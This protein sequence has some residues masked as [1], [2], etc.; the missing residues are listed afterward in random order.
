MF[1]GVL[2]A[3]IAGYI[4]LVG[5]IYVGQRGLMY[6]PGG[7][8]GPPT[9][10]GVGEM[11]E[12]PLENDAGHTLI[13]WYAAPKPN[14]PV[15]IFFHG[16][17]GTIGDRAEKI[18]PYLNAGFGVVLA[19]YRG[20]GGNPGSPSEAGL[21]NDAATILGHL[22]TNGIPP[23]R[24]VVYGESLGTGVATEMAHRYAL[25]D[26]P[27]GAVV[28]EAPFTSMGDVAAVHYPYI[29][30]RRLVCDKYDSITKIDAINTPLM[31]IH[32]AADRTVPQKLGRRLFDA[33]KKP[34]FSL[35]LEKPGHNNL[36]DFGAA[37]HIIRF[38]RSS[39]DQ[40]LPI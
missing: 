28:L 8:I 3:V 21:Y 22:R 40:R 38:V 27:V 14:Q 37:T 9:A 1:S 35:W 13:S 18:R 4:C 29:P 6:H 19:G 36:Y 23:K 12:L 32:G 34:K 10:Y 17:A 7:P 16:N 30:T 5:I 26:A 33:A 11:V 24:W 31:I 15:L 25:A 20:F 39:V 2:T